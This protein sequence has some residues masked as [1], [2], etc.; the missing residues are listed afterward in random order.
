MKLQLTPS[1]DPKKGSA[2]YKMMDCGHIFCRDCLQDF[3]SNAIKEGD[4]GTVRCLSPSCAKEREVAQSQDP[5]KKHRK[6]K[7]YIGPSELLQIGLSQEMV[8]RYVN[9]KYKNELKSDKNTIYCPRKWCDGAAKSKKHKKP[10]GLELEEASDDEAHEGPS[11]PTA[12]ERLRSFKAEDLLA[13]CEDCGFAFC[14]R[15]QQSWHGEFIRCNIKRDTDE[16]SAEEAASLKYLEFHTSPCPTCDAPSQKTHGC[17]HMICFLCKTHFCYLCTS[18][19]DPSNPYAHFNKLGANQCYQRLWELEE[20]DGDDVGVNF[21]GG[22]EQQHLQRPRPAQRQ[23]PPGRAGPVEHAVV[24]DEQGVEVLRV[25]PEIEEPDDDD[26]DGD[27][28][29][30][31]EEDDAEDAN[32]GVARE[33]PL[34]LRIG[35]GRRPGRTPPPVPPAVPAPPEQGRGG[36]RLDRPPRGRGGG[37][38]GGRGRGNRGGA[39]RGAAQRNGLAVA[40]EANQPRENDDELDPAQ[41]AWVRHF[42]L[43]A[44]ND[45]EDSGSDDDEEILLFPN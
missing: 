41:R 27:D 1:L 7:T 21:A 32:V 12:E 13:I 38:A 30:S 39:R 11:S 8:Q 29:S 15:C 5:S 31:A 42:V 6:P 16:L 4:L 18:W 37:P 17:N 43:M 3:Y 25:V 26:S 40:D 34:V 22:V 23:L 45:E 2:C 14:S 10:K 20:G 33:G 28:P 36:R 44:L 9:L 24:R 35:G 19:L